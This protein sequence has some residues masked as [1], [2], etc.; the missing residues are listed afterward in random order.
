[1]AAEAQEV[2]VQEAEQVHSELR[3]E[4]EELEKQVEMLDRL[5]NKVYEIGQTCKGEPELNPDMPN[6]VPAN[7]EP[8]NQDKSIEE[9]FTN[10][11]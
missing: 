2:A 8:E 1:M 10:D 7:R 5:V 9:V 11:E 6:V 4:I 3:E